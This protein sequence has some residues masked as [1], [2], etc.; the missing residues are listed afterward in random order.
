VKKQISKAIVVFGCLMLSAILPDLSF[1]KDPTLKEKIAA[2]AAEGKFIP[3][4]YYVLSYAG[5]KGR[6]YRPPDLTPY[7]LFSKKPMPDGYQA[8][9]DTVIAALNAGYGVTCFKSFPFDSLPKKESRVWGTVTDWLATDYKIYVSVGL[10]G[11]YD[12]N[13]SQY[14]KSIK[15]IMNCEITIMESYDKKGEKKSDD[16]KTLRPSA[17]TKSVAVKTDY[18]KFEQFTNDIPADAL[19][20]EL[21]AA[22]AKEVA[23]YAAK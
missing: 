2:L 10:S 1:A 14:G 5:I 19:I 11:E 13:I 16:I 7:D 22:A 23:K 20:N 15:L 3:V 6:Q 12:L 4:V 18:N 8:V 21:K 17:T 9:N